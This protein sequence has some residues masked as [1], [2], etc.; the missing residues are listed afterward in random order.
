MEK[1]AERLANARLTRNDR[2]VLDFILKN[3]GEACFMTAAELAKTLQVS[4]SS[5]I[6][7]SSKLGFEN[8]TS[9]KREL[10]RELAKDR[11]GRRERIPYEKIK[12]YA[13]FTEEELIRG[14]KENALRNVEADQTA[15][16]YEEYRKAAA[17]ISGARR[18]YIAG[19]RACGGFAS[20]LGVMLG[21]IRPDVYVVSG[22][23]PAVDRL[24]DLSEKDAV[25]AISFERYSSDT[26]FAVRMAREAGSHIIALTDRLTSP[27][28]S[29][30]DAVI[31]NSCSGLSFY[32]SYTSL[33]MAMEV[34]T[35]L[36][37][38]RCREQNEARLIK[39]ERYLEETGQY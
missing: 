5:V 1:M 11:M 2:L 31:F 15:E 23:Q 12:D 7:V 13:G 24:V 9:F 28:C 16:D 26:V 21:C 38:R 35:G 14:I 33:V 29:G 19:F 4:P 37:S 20:S 39:M 30:A 32:N 3:K 27:L 25:I 34:L 8:F 22:G 17:L 18:V 10:Q 36:V 6:R